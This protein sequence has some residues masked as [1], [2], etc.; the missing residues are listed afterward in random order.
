MSADPLEAYRRR[1]GGAAVVWL[2]ATSSLV[3]CG[4]LYA[5]TRIYGTDMGPW[6]PVILLGFPASVVTIALRAGAR[7][8]L[9]GD[10][11]GLLSGVQALRRRDDRV[12]R[13][14]ARFRWRR[15]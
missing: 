8:L 1:F 13:A 2:V 6:V 12:P 7:M 14:H 10:Q 5:I 9:P 3:T 15:P 11:P 4:G